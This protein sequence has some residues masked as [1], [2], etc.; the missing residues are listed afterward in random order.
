[1]RIVLQR[2][3]CASVAVADEIIGKIGR[4]IL[5]LVSVGQE[6]TTDDAA[7]IAEKIATLRIFRDEHNKMNLSVQDVNGAVLVVS[8]FTLHGDCRRGRRPSFVAAAPPEKAVPLYEQVIAD[9]REK[10]GLTVASGAFGA[11]MQVSL[12]NDGPVTL[13]LDSHKNF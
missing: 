9:L 4:G 3:S 12:L 6:D 13:M 7:L 5:A 8:Q 1:M 11:Y 10:Y 2:V